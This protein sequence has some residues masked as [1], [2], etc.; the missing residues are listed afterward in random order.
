M[1]PQSLSVNPIS[2]E[3]MANF[4]DTSS[5]S[6]LSSTPTLPPDSDLLIPGP[7][8]VNQYRMDVV[9]DE[10]TIE[11]ALNENGQK[12][13]RKGKEPNKIRLPP[14]PMSLFGVIRGSL[15]S[16]GSSEHQLAANAKVTEMIVNHDMND[17]NRELKK[18]VQ[19]ARKKWKAAFNK[20]KQDH[21]EML[22]AF[23]T[24]EVSPL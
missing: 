13:K 5:L 11:Q 16:R 19:S 12:H 2:R 6:S 14:V 1:A 4:S 3:E 21:P 7:S 18:I 8:A 24:M 17:L 10:R 9:H 23:K 15:G 22:N 20:A